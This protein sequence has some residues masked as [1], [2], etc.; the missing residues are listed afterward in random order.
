MGWPLLASWMNIKLFWH[1][2]IQSSM[3]FLRRV[4][5][6]LVQRVANLLVS[7][8][9]RDKKRTKLSSALS[10]LPPS[11]GGWWP[12]R[13][14]FQHT[15]AVCVRGLLLSNAGRFLGALLGWRVHIVNW[16]VHEL[17]SHFSEGFPL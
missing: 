13:Y 15:P 11:S 2:E 6:S 16:H 8:L 12:K 17:A 4:Y 9:A 3:E 5:K 10:G 1:F 14:L 7:N